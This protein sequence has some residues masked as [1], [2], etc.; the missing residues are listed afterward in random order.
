[1]DS[2]IHY[3]RLLKEIEGRFDKPEWDSIR[4]WLE[5]EAQKG[6]VREESFLPTSLKSLTDGYTVALQPGDIVPGPLLT[7]AERFTIPAGSQIGE[8]VYGLGQVEIE[9]DCQIMGDV[10]A[11]AEIDWRGGAESSVRNLVAPQIHL[12]APAGVVYGGIWCDTI[13]SDERDAHLLPGLLVQ[14]QVVVDEPAEGVLV[15]G[16]DTHIGGL[17][18]QG[19]IES[20]RGVVISHLIAQGP[21]RIGRNNRIGQ[22]EGSEVWVES[23]SQ[24]GQII[25][26]GDVAIKRGVTVDSIRAVGHI[27][28]DANV[29]I[30]GSALLSEQGQLRIPEGNAW[31]MQRQRWFYRL[32]DQSLHPYVEGESPPPNSSLLALR[33]LTH[34]LWAQ[35]ESLAGRR[36]NGSL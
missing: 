10:L 18:V 12:R 27:S 22:V 1:M 21:V 29:T 35:L 16:A 8:S 26:H 30:T 14:G 19:T 20:Q 11:L 15:V 32:P 13:H 5:E 7:R 3:L 4:G 6:R 23:G 25:S 28:L 2:R 9:Q 33:S 17:Y 31:H 24:V 36:D 34:H